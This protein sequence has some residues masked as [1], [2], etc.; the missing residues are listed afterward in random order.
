MLSFHWL[1]ELVHPLHGTGYQFWS[2]IGSDFGEVTLL[3]GLWLFYRTH[4]CHVYRCLRLAWHPHPASGHPV[5]RKH[6]PE[7]G[8]ISA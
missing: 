1:N 4:N 6:H 7:Q 8:K 3:A 2:G 5:C